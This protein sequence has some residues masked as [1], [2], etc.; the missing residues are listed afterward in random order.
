MKVIL[1]AG[2][3]GFDFGATNKDRK[4]K[5]DNLALTL[6]VGERLEQAGIPVEYTRTQDIYQSPYE[7]ADIANASDADYFISIHRNAADEP[8][9]GSGVET[10]VF[11]ETS[12]LMALAEAINQNLERV[13]YENL[14]VFPRPDLV[15]L[16]KI[17]MPSLLI[18][19][20]FIDNDKDNEIFDRNFNEIASAIADAI[21]Q[22]NPMAMATINAPKPVLYRVNV[23]VFRNEA[24]AY[25]LWRELI[26]KGY[27]AFIY[28]KDGYHF[29]QVGAYRD[30]KDATNMENRLRQA[31]YSTY[32]TT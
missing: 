31:G 19:A 15:V 8:G 9:T 26:I 22:S 20:G 28:R 16:N 6:A 21:I 2:H 12:D 11:D 32:I 7:K 10:L 24:Y 14:G 3:G 27:P 4:E 17:K 13:G 29:V 1:D 18:E 25:D 30:L 23:G 5:N